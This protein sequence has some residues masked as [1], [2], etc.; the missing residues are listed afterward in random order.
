MKDIFMVVTENTNKII[1]YA[2]EEA[3]RLMS[4][5]LEP[6]HF[7][8]AIIRLGKGSAYELLEKCHFDFEQAKGALEGTVRGT[9]QQDNV[10]M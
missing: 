10:P 4:E 7:L 2:Q 9:V 3:G 6:A 1:L 8:L 5:K